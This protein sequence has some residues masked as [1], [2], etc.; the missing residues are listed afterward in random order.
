M[1][2]YMKTVSDFED[3][4][5]LFEKHGVR[6]L[7]IGGV[8][9]V[10][11]VKPRYTK[12]IDLWVEPEAGNIRKANAAL[13]EFG[14]PFFLQEGKEGE[15]VQIGVAPNRIDL[16]QKIEGV[17]FDGAWKKRERS[18]YGKAMANWIDMDSLI[19]VKERIKDPKHQ[20]DARDLRKVKEMKAKRKARSGKM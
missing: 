4:L 11:H 15:F 8:A 5:T 7:I 17:T 20:Q 2:E 1:N 6:Y 9:F 14:S 3:M 10:F 16:I 12:D 18:A 19:K 13:K